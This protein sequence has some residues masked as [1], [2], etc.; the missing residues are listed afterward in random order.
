MKSTEGFGSKHSSIQEP[1]IHPVFLYL[2]VLL[3]LCCF[4]SHS[5]DELFQV[6]VGGDS[7]LLSQIYFLQ[8]FP[9]LSKIISLP[10]LHICTWTYH[11]VQ[12]RG[13]LYC[14]KNWATRPLL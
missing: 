6:V 10:R 9:I 8:Y 11:C 4:L 3:F 2:L 1:H 7:C 12:R 13:I 5:A 14:V